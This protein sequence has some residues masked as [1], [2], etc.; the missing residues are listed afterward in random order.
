MA[1]LLGLA[2]SAQAVRPPLPKQI[3]VTTRNDTTIQYLVPPSEEDLEPPSEEDLEPS[4]DAAGDSPEPK[5]VSGRRTRVPSRIEVRYTAAN[6]K[7]TRVEL[8]GLS[9]GHLPTCGN[10]NQETIEGVMAPAAATC[11]NVDDIAVPFMIGH[12]EHGSGHHVSIHIPGLFHY[13]RSVTPEG[14]DTSFTSFLD[15]SRCTYKGPTTRPPGTTEP[16]ELPIRFRF[17]PA[18]RGD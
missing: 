15:G 8:H 10:A 14:E 18:R 16:C 12:V 4:T 7:V 3:T 2:G 6:G 9:T 1:A 5:R 17:G 13:E 11:T